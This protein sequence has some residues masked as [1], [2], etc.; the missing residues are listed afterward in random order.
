MGEEQLKLWSEKDEAAIQ[1]WK[2]SRIKSY[3]DGN[4]RD[5]HP[6][7]EAFDAW[8]E[9]QSQGSKNKSLWK[10]T[11]KPVV[12]P[13]PEVPKLTKETAR[14]LLDKA[15]AEFRKPANKAKLEGILKECETGGDDAGGMMKMMKLMPAVQ[16]MMGPTLTEYGLDPSN[17]MGV[18]MQIQAFAAE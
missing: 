6:T 7:R 10:R 8:L 15:L 13:T 12:T 5:V 4:M 2:D 17:V 3:E 14:T 1:K 9:K 11:K 18:T 16:G